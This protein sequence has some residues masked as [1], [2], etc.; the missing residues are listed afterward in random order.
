MPYEISFDELPDGVAETSTRKG[1]ICNVVTC[2]FVSSEDGDLLIN[3]LDGFPSALTARCG[4]KSSAVENLLAIL[5]R[6]NTVSVYIDELGFLIDGC[7]KRD[8]EA[9][10]EVTINDF[11]ATILHLLGLD[12]TKLSYYHNGTRRRLTDVHGE[13]IDNILA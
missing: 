2:E 6:D 13:V 3:R 7:T 4:I 11:H 10:D 9:G 12:H 1:E 5:R 8:A